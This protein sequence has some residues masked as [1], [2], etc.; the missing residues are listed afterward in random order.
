MDELQLLLEN[1]VL[2]KGKKRRETVCKALL[3]ETCSDEKICMNICIRKNL[4]VQLGD[5]IS[6]QPCPNINYGKRVHVLP[7][8]DT[9]KGVTGFAYNFYL[10]IYSKN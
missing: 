2:I 7:I 8:D 6:V 4:R 9:I 1:T 10:Y 3:D 5:F